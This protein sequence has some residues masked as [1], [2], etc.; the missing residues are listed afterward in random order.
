MN[1]SDWLPRPVQQGLIPGQPFSLVSSR[2]ADSLDQTDPPIPRSRSP[3]ERVQTETPYTGAIQNLNELILE[4]KKTAEDLASIR[5]LKGQVSI[6]VGVAEHINLAKPRT[7]AIIGDGI[8]RVADAEIDTTNA[9]IASWYSR[10]HEVVAMLHTGRRSCELS[11]AAKRRILRSLENAGESAALKTTL[12]KSLTAAS[13]LVVKL[14]IIESRWIPKGKLVPAGRLIR[15]VEEIESIL[16]HNCQEYVILCDPYCSRRTLSILEAT[17][18][19]IPITVLTMR[20]TDDESFKE[21]L[22]RVRKSGRVIDVKISEARP[23][24]HDRY[25]ITHSHGWTVGT[26]IKDIGNRDT[27]I[28]ELEN[29]AEVENMIRNYLNGSHGE[30]IT[31]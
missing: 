10:L 26:S 18:R 14:T 11:G 30:I 25:V 29:R 8:K 28:H 7:I 13:N 4:G 5:K 23:G 22:E 1:L 31:L 21:G 9:R 17:P 15:G 20:I 27:L 6:G 2:G 16:S 3:R 24:F 12:M 19:E